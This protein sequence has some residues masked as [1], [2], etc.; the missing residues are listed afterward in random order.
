MK[1]E[2]VCKKCQI[3]VSGDKCLL[4]NGN[5][6]VENWRGKVIIFNPE[7]SEIAQHLKFKQKGRYA[8]KV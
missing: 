5:Q 8:I 4:C 1:G 6:L 7:K 2:K 3:M